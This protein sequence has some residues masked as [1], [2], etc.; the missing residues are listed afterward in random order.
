MP[1]FSLV[2]PGDFDDYEWEVKVKGF[3]SEARLSVS[4]K[5]YRLTFYDPIRLNQEIEGELQ[6]G[7]LFFEPNL[8]IVNSV[9]R[10]DME[11][12]VEA[13]MKSGQEAFLIGE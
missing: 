10:S 3:F 1:I 6:R 7:E 8:V 12:A 13:L 2:L 5:R 9:T 11:R 4:G